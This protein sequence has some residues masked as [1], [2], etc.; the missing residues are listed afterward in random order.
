[1]LNFDIRLD[2][3]YNA[4]ATT[5]GAGTVDSAEL[6]I[7]K[8]AGNIFV[9]VAARA[10]GTAVTTVSVLH[11]EETGTGFTAVPAS[12]L[13]NPQTG[14]ADT[15]TNIPNAGAAT[16]ETLAL[17]RQQ[18]KRFVLI[19]FGGTDIDQNIA[20]VAAGQADYTEFS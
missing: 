20:V 16:D 17:N 18:L 9:N 13:F 11:S 19:Q 5:S 4:N 7:T 15:F 2:N 3:L 12:A 10:T 14:D 6:D 1:M 8:F